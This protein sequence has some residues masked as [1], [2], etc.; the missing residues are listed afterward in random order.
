MINRKKWLFSLPSPPLQPLDSSSSPR[1]DFILM[2]T[3]RN[4]LSI[5]GAL[6][7]LIVMTLT[8][9]QG[10]RSM[11]VPTDSPMCTASE[12]AHY[13]LTFFGKWTRAAFPKQYPLYRPS[14]QWSN[15][16]G[17]RTALLCSHWSQTWRQTWNGILIGRWTD[18][19]CRIRHPEKYRVN[20]KECPG[21]KEMAKD[22]S[23]LLKVESIRIYFSSH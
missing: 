22:V 3:S 17:K 15:L 19:R 5:S 1:S 2:D 9:G 14:A 6:Y 7:H 16:I 20:T 10:A 12:T 4:I 23:Y 11:P 8:L 13:K 18:S 21:W